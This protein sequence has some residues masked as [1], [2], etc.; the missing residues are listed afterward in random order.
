MLTHPVYEGT[1]MAGRSTSLAQASSGQAHTS[2]TP[3]SAANPRCRRT[4]IR[5][6]W[7]GTY[8][9][10][11]T[12]AQEANMANTQPVV[13]ELNVVAGK[14]Y[15]LHDGGFHHENSVLE[16]MIALTS[17]DWFVE[18]ITQT[19]W[20]QKVVVFRRRGTTK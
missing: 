8:A 18:S 10:I 6:A 5:L 1:S 9:R 4:R 14:W 13:Y 20:D 17:A 7:A 15:D 11:S 12:D 16:P 19:R 3:S 2:S